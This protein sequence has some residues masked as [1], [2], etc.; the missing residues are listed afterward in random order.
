[1]VSEGTGVWT[2]FLNGSQKAFEQIYYEHVDYL[3]DYGMRICRDTSVVED[4]L[5]DMFSHLWEK[6]EVLSEVTSVR[7]YLLVALRRRIIRNLTTKQKQVDQPSDDINAYARD[8]DPYISSDLSEDII[9]QI[10][11][12]F[13]KLSDKQKEVIYLRFYNQLTYAEIADVLSITTKAVYKL[14]ARA[15]QAMRIQVK[16]PVYPIILLIILSV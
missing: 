14:M 10:R 12:A 7:T 2:L 4:C 3:Y 6:R 15:I 1:M 9:D 13:N 11:G 5:Q 8:F 16:S